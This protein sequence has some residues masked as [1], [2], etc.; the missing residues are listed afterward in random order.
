[1]INFEKKK[2]VE[3]APG[4]NQGNRFDQINKAAGDAHR[5]SDADR[6]VRRARSTDKNKDQAEG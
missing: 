3:P 1:M 2:Q 4:E 6:A 5:K